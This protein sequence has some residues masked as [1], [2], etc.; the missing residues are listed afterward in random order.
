MPHIFKVGDRVHFRHQRIV[1]A[2][3]GFYVVT[4]QLPERGGE[5]EYHI[6]SANEPHERTARESE[7]RG[8]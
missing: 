2:A 3:N 5:F 7:L 1:S 4:M 8:A 6:R